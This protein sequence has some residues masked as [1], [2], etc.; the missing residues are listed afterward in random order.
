M[1]IAEY[2]IIKN[3]KVFKDIIDAPF[4]GGEYH[5][6]FNSVKTLPTEEQIQNLTETQNLVVINDGAENEAWEVCEKTI[7][8][9]F[10]KKSDASF[11]QEIRIVDQALFTTI[12]PLPQYDDA[13]QMFFDDKQAWEYTT[14]NEEILKIE[15][16]EAKL[17][18]KN[19][20]LAFKKAKQLNQCKI[21]I[22]DT[23]YSIT[24]DVSVVQNMVKNKLSGS[25]TFD[26]ELKQY[27]KII[28]FIPKSVAQEFASQIE[29][30]R[31]KCNTY[32]TYYLGYDNSLV[33]FSSVGVIDKCVNIQ[34]L[35]EVNFLEHIIIGG[36]SFTTT[37]LL[38]ELHMQEGME[39]C[40]A[41]TI[42]G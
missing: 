4:F 39:I 12:P 20:F 42:D 9:E 38:L 34:E 8:G 32:E 33:D 40:E 37:Y 10:F 22:V 13:S 35:N 36:E 26:Y 41:V 16:Q 25:D 24:G 29:T 21:E 27:N 17:Q 7:E 31:T 1:Q 19:D 23:A 11:F 5:L 15:L 18:K 2:E 14:K 28:K 6:I 30:Y 3:Q